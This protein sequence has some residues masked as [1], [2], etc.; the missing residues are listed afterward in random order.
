MPKKEPVKPKS[1]PVK[2]NLQ[3]EKPKSQ[4]VRQTQEKNLNQSQPASHPSEIKP[5]QAEKTVPVPNN[6]P[7]AP[8]KAAPEVKKVAEVA[9]EVKKPQTKPQEKAAAKPVEKP[10]VKVAEKPEPRVEEKPI[11]A[12][13]KPK[14]QDPLYG[15]SKPLAMASESQQ[16]GALLPAEVKSSSSKKPAGEK[17]K[18]RMK[19][20]LKAVLVIDF[21]ILLLA[22]ALYLPF[23]PLRKNLI[24]G[25][26]SKKTNRH[27]V[28]A[29]YSQKMI[30]E[31]VSEYLRPGK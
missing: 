14:I 11:S 26:L 23:S 29:L 21:L 28:Y 30:D 4:P 20:Y 9:A 5:K 16:P 22:G 6:Q 24:I 13:P 15:K 31:T 10:E 18:A 27:L 8:A 17:K 1:E 3:T 2:A 12:V 19:G 25:S 7:K